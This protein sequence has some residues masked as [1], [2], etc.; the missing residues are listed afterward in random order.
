[1]DSFEFNKIAG[2]VLATLM[3]VLGVNI[4][5]GE[6]FTAPT[7]EEPGYQI[8]VAEDDPDAPV[9]EEPA[10]APLAVRLAEADAAAG[11]SAVRPCASCHTFEQGGEDRVGPNLYNT[12]G[13]QKAHIEGFGYSDAMEEA[14]AAGEVW[15]Y[16]S[17]D[18]FFEDPRGYLP[19]TTM[20]FAGVGDADT[21]ADIILYMREMTDDPPAL[22]EVE[23]APT[24]EE[25]PAEAPAEDAEEPTE[26]AEA[27][28]DDLHAMIAAADPADGESAARPCAACH[29][30][31]EGG[32]DRVG[33]NLYN[34]VGNQKAHIEG[35][36]YSDAMEEAAAAGEVW[37]YESL[38]AFLEDPRGYLPGTTMAFAGVRD[39][40]D[41]A[42]LIAYMREM[43]DDPPAL[44]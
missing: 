9:E 27:P 24:E 20:A 8:A 19:G 2:A 35:F 30:F 4:L 29:T 5:A 10:E 16:E 25:A 11:E 15:D 18:A 6:L 17:L 31:E 32:E 23:E 1:M 34:T 40:E 26:E 33:P 21:R 38:D 13:N 7:P 41:R 14:A 37:D 44:D 43:S 42:A 12:V 39:P 22:P 28:G 36:G 3:V